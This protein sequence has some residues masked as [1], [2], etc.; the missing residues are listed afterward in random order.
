VIN[1]LVLV[2]LVLAIARGTRLITT[3]EITL[4]LRTWVV[5]KYGGDGK[6]AYFVFCPWCVSI[7]VALLFVS[8]TF[9]FEYSPSLG[10]WIWNGFLTILASSH[11]TGLIASKLEN[12]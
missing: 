3:D 1:A 10:R 6:A 4:P 2:V 9:Y 5:R 8:P 7:W 12:D 11:M